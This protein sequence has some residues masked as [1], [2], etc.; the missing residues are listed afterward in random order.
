M[1]NTNET[2]RYSIVSMRV[3]DAERKAIQ[4]IALQK[5]LSISKTM[6]QAMEQFT[7]S[8]YNTKFGHSAQR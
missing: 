7:N 1:D 6:R 3:S 4:Q 5:K 8:R 2:P